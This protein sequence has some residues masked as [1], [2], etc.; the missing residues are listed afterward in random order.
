MDVHGAQ[1]R[2]ADAGLR[3][4]VKAQDAHVLRHVFADG[5]QRAHQI[6]RHK[7]VGAEEH[8]RQLLQVGQGFHGGPLYPIAA[9]AIALIHRHARHQHGEA[10]SGVALV[11]GLA[12]GVITDEADARFSL[13]QY[14][15]HKTEDLGAVVH[16]QLIRGQRSALQ[17]GGTI[18]EQSG[19]PKL[20]DHLVIV[21]VEHLDAEDGFDPLPLKGE[22][23]ALLSHV[24]LRDPMCVHGVAHLGDFP[25]ELV[26]QGGGKV[27]L[28][29]KGGG[30]QRDLPLIAG[31]HSALGVG[32]SGNGG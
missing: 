2:A 32:Q 7:V 17:L 16:V 22:R 18:H 28:G 23:Q 12:V 1:R 30:Q 26:Q 11:K 3:R 10:E 9:E 31:R 21:V 29:Q 13:G 24:P 8:V 4:V 19:D 25:L 15:V 27:R 6:P 14:V 20:A 5:V